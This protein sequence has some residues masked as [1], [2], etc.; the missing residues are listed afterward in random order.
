MIVV[1]G[2]LVVSIPLWLAL[3]TVLRL[4]RTLG[5]VDGS[6]VGDAIAGDPSIDLEKLTKRLEVEASGSIP[7]RLLSSCVREEDRTKKLALAEEVA[8]IERAIGEGQR[9]PRVAASLATTGGLFAA[10]LVMREGLGTT[11]PEG[12]DPVPFFYAVIDKGL[13]LA[14]VAVFGGIVCAS[15]HR[16]AQKERRARLEE[17]DAMVEPLCTRLFGEGAEL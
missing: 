8:E 17:L 6:A 14:A 2:L 9:V 12:A 7:Q 10:A 5:G 4:T 1:V 13:T 15:L 3:S 16:Q 11:L